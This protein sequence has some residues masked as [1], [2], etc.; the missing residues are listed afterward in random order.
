MKE[1][2]RIVGIII[3][4]NCLLLVKGDEKFKEFWTTWG[5]NEEWESHME[6]LK[7]E[8]LE[9][10]WLETTAAEF[11]WEY[12]EKAP[13]TTED[14][15]SRS[16]VYI[17]ST[18]WIITVGHEIKSFVWMSKAEFEAGKYKLL[19]GTRE[20]IIPDLIKKWLLT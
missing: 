16:F 11:F 12:T 20:Q 3:Q 9:E 2:I 15:I 10:V 13:Y 14:K 19:P 5:T 6:T 1:I 4:N 17:I 8:I 18:T 7:R